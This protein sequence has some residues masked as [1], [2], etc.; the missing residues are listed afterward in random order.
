MFKVCSTSKPVA[1]QDNHS[2]CLHTQSFGHE[3]AGIL[4]GGLPRWEAE[5]LPIETGEPSAKVQPTKYTV[6]KL[7]ESAVRCTL[8]SF[9]PFRFCS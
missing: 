9:T 7:N 2:A 6:P 8:L 4:D 1:G 3:K 5:G